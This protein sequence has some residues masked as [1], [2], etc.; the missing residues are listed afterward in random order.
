MITRREFLQASVAASAIVGLSGFGNWSKL[1][2]Q[3][4]LTESQLLQFDDFGN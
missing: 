1:A 4:A 3:Q 2:A